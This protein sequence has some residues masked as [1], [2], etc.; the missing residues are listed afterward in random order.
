[1]GMFVDVM[2]GQAAIVI[3]GGDGSLQPCGLDATVTRRQT[4]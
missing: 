2:C 1:M 4:F 3:E